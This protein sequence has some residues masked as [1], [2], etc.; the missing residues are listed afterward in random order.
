MTRTLQGVIFSSY[1][2]L[3]KTVGI[4]GGKEK[5]TTRAQGIKTLM[6]NN[7]RYLKLNTI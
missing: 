1:H 5:T 3:K 4:P 6:K 7:S 2:S